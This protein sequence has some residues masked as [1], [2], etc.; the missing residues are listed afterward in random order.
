MKKLIPKTIALTFLLGL[1]LVAF[2]FSAN[3]Y[4]TTL[5]AGSAQ[6]FSITD[7]GQTGLDPAGDFSVSLWVKLDTVSEAASHDYGWVTKMN[8][9]PNKQY[10]FFYEFDHGSPVH[11]LIFDT[12]TDGILTN[13]HRCTYTGSALNTSGQWNNIVATYNS[14]TGDVIFYVNGTSACTAA[15]TGGALN[16]GAAKSQNFLATEGQA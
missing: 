11:T 7:A 14:S 10:S 8:T 16:D 1:P 15:G 2:G 6:S 12:S 5:T 9:A 4:S 13:T 3:T